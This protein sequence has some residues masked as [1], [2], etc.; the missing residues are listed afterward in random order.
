MN[1]KILYFINPVSGPKRRKLT[2]E[3]L[4][5]KTL[6][7]N[8]FF[9]ILF[10]T[11]DGEYPFLVDKIKNEGF[12]DVVVCGGDGSVN[13]VTAYLLG[14]D[15]NIGIIPIGSGNGLA[16]AAKIP[17]NINKALKLIFA[18]TPAFIDGFFINEKF[19]C[20][21]CGVGFDAQVAHDFAM[22]P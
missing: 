10:T 16:L 19:S 15:V 1:R 8:I 13:Q 9:E 20:M 3:W 22:K 17:R 4:I 11:P 6:E 18:G 7:Q 21:L 5:E 2:P 12:T 14:M